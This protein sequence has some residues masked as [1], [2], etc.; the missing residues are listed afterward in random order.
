MILVL[1]V[2]VVPL[3]LVL[4]A[5]SKG[6]FDQLG[7]GPFSTDDLSPPSSASGGHS[8]SREELEAETRQFVAARNYR[9][10]A[11]G[12]PALDVDSEVAKL[13]ALDPANGSDLSPE[14]DAELREEV[15][16]LVVARNERRKAKGEPPLDIEAEIDRQLRE[17][18]A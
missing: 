13:M 7:G 18:G 1:V 9:L 4:F 2:V 12:E 11:R 15:R 10:A 16:T 8:S 6:M 5:D 14:V 3:A 17:A